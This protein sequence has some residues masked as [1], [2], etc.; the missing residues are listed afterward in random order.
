MIDPALGSLIVVCIMTLLV[1][2]AAHK[3]RDPVRFALVLAAYRVL[4]QAA[5]RGLAWTVPC[6]ELAIALAL[7]WPRTRRWAALA[8]AGLLLLYA[9]GMA[10]NLARGR[11]DLDCG[12]TAAGRRRPI[13]PWMVWRNLALALASA[14]AALSWAPR[15]LEGVDLLTIAAGAVAS[16]VLYA[17]LDRL[18]GEV[19]PRAALLRSKA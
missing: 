8:A 1:T 16:L 13:A 10:L 15:A 17:A 19:A 4:P 5:A 12:C 7:P 18:V 14:T 9:A 2:A 3:L 11:R 6:A